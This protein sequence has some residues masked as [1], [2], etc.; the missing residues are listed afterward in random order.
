[1]CPRCKEKQQAKKEISIVIFPQTLL[2]H[3]KRFKK[4]PFDG[5]VFKKVQCLVVYEENKLPIEKLIEKNPIIVDLNNNHSLNLDKMNLDDNSTTT[6]QTNDEETNNVVRKNNFI[7]L[8]SLN[9]IG[10]SINGGHY[11]ATAKRLAP[12][13]RIISTVEEKS[14]TITDK[15]LEKQEKVFLFNDGIVSKMEKFMPTFE[16][17]MILYHQPSIN[18]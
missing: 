11:V 1:M 7:F 3:F 8:A 14:T 4:N 9:H 13:I 5:Q 10:E 17:Y 2:L 6:K 12:T 15:E 18:I 16:S